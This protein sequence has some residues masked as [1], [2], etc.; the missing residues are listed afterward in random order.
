MIQQFPFWMFNPKIKKTYTTQC[1][2][3]HYSHQPGHGNNPSVHQ[4]MN[5][6]STHTHIL[7]HISQWNT[8]QPEK[9]NKIFT[10][11]TTWIDLEDIMLSEIGQ[12]EKDK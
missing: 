3:Q 10:F 1:S 12:T 6:Q 7:T 11:A 9:N 5:G 4:Q 2:Q 8:T